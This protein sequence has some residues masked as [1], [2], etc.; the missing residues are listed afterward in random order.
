MKVAISLPD[1][2]FSAAEELAQRL[3]LSRSQLYARAIEEYLKERQDSLITERL[4]ALYTQG[5]ESVDSP[6][7]TAQL[8]A[9]GREAW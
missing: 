8:E 1:P 7:A 3:R 5:Q 6:L 4:N 9:I 2:I